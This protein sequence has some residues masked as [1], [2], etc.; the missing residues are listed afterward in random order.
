MYAKD[1]LQNDIFAHL[2]DQTTL[3]QHTFGTKSVKT[4]TNRGDYLRFMY[5]STYNGDTFTTVIN[6]LGDFI[7]YHS[8]QLAKDHVVIPSYDELSQA[9][10]PVAWWFD[11]Q[12]DKYQCPYKSKNYLSDYGIHPEFEQRMFAY[13]SLLTWICMMA[14]TLAYM[15]NDANDIQGL[16][17]AQSKVQEYLN[18]PAT[19]AIMNCHAE[20]KWGML[21]FYSLHDNPLLCEYGAISGC[22]EKTYQPHKDNHG[23]KSIRNTICTNLIV[24][25]TR[26]GQ[27]LDFWQIYPLTVFSS[28]PSDYLTTYYKLW[29]LLTPT[30]HHLLERTAEG[31]QLLALNEIFR[32]HKTA[33][34]F[35]ESVASH[36]SGNLDS[37]D[38]Y[39]IP[40][41]VN[42]QTL[43]GLIESGPKREYPIEVIRNLTT[44]NNLRTS[45][46]Q[47]HSL[48]GL[49]DDEGAIS[50]QVNIFT[51]DML[52]KL[53]AWTYASYYRGLTPQHDKD[54]TYEFKDMRY[55][56]PTTTTSASTG[57]TTTTNV[58]TDYKLPTIY[59][60]T[61]TVNCS[62][63]I[64]GC[65]YG[66][67]TIRGSGMYMFNKYIP[68]EMKT[69]YDKQSADFKHVFTLSE[70][71]QGTDYL[72]VYRPFLP[73]ISTD[74]VNVGCE[75]L[76][77]QPF[78][79]AGNRQP[80]QGML[81][82]E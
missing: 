17:G 4:L 26:K 64:M 50:N 19:T 15:E 51:A 63:L 62:N 69:W 53:S 73:N 2:F 5:G 67:S 74:N 42:P 78:S 55:Q 72:T 6:D 49:L 46:Y 79:F 16:H 27:I 54:N 3:V 18:S 33:S 48:V 1:G 43:F 10:P 35:N 81:K 40:T 56:R 47:D 59:L 70:S 29:Y 71:V 36:N 45:D 30:W 34:A 12:G 13:E 61:E 28:T 60:A 76:L 20:L 58:Q 22:D 32:G 82:C 38:V 68:S 14:I 41:N 21:Y 77:K 31:Q 75:D 24:S 23:Y 52:A 8:Y 66:I 65:G 9:K 57:T 11:G 80:D 37:E 7:E 25:E 44:T 39:V